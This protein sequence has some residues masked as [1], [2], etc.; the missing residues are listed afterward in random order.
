MSTKDTRQHHEEVH[1]S[2]VGAN[3]RPKGQ[4]TRRKQPQ[5]TEVAEVGSFRY[6][7]AKP[8]LST[9]VSMVCTAT[10]RIQVIFL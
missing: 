4:G 9:S 10:F 6:S 1:P 5:E 8:Y 3:R 7:R 2:R